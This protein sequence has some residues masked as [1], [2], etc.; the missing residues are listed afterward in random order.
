MNT[1]VH[2]YLPEFFL[3]WEMVQ[4]KLVKKIKIHTLYSTTFSENR[5]VYKMMSKNMLEPGATD[6]NVAHA[7]CMLDN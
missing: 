5:T 4:L 7:L 3:K 1:Y 6:D 2:L